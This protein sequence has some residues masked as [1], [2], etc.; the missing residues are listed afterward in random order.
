MEYIFVW[1]FNGTLLPSETNSF[2]LPRDEGDYEVEFINVATGCK[3]FAATYVQISEPPQISAHVITQAFV[4]TNSIEVSAAAIGTQDFEYRLDNGPWQSHNIFENVSIGE[5]NITVKNLSGCGYSSIKT[6]VMDYP[7]YFTPNGDGTNDTWHVFGLHSQPEAKVTIFD[8]YGKLIKQLSAT[9][10]GW[11]G[12]FNGKSLPGDDYW[13]IIEYV[14]PLD[15][16]LKTFKS[17]F[18][19]VR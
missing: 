1:R 5:H 13:F 9:S 7:S 8:R 6:F 4:E 16:Q 17:H 19:L 3:N 18:S 2:I 12:N 11:D 15:N 14:E 10:R